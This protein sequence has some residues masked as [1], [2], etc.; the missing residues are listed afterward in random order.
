MKAVRG[1]LICGY[2][3][4]RNL[5]DD[6]IL[7]VILDR[8]HRS[9][10]SLKVTVLS[11]DPSATAR[12]FGIHAV[13]RYDF[14]HI[15]SLMT[16]GRMLILGGGGLIQ[17]QTS[18][19]SLFY[20]LFMAGL[21]LLLKKKVFF[22]AVGIETL[23]RPLSRHL[24]K[25]ILNR[26]NVVLTV[27]DQKSCQILDELG[28]KR[29]KITVTA[30]PVFS[31][32]ASSPKIPR[33]ITSGPLKVLIITRT[34]G[35][36]GAEDIFGEIEKF[37]KISGVQSIKKMS[38]QPYDEDLKALLGGSE[39]NGLR[40]HLG[41]PD[42][43]ISARYHGLVMALMLG[44]PF[45]GIGDENKIGRLCREFDR[46]FIPWGTPSQLLK[47]KISEALTSNPSPSNG[48]ME[49]WVRASQR[50]SEVFGSFVGAV[51]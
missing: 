6:L 37:L 33:S 29:E 14:I 45:V 34:G 42:L 19:R 36:K 10:P 24:V 12:D 48:Q 5:G 44:V 38:F 25:L 9:E 1:C 7:R 21:A 40:S 43:I 3:G 28:I 13:W 23:H 18:F 39:E 4:F 22:Y 27:R 35:P 41:S 20:Y 11:A 2:Y 51:R 50:T 47:V 15:I 26:K 17:D 49:K 32:E 8:L 46:P 31:L 30:D 16:A